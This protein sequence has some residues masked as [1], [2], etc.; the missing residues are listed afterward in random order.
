MEK[1]ATRNPCSRIF[2]SVIS[3][4]GGEIRNHGATRQA[5]RVQPR[6][7]VP[8]ARRPSPERRR[9]L[10]LGACPPPPGSPARL[11]QTETAL[12]EEWRSLWFLAPLLWQ[13]CSGV[14]LILSTEGCCIICS[15]RQQMSGLTLA[16]W[17]PTPRR[18]VDNHAHVPK[19]FPPLLRFA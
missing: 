6:S 10:Y 8:G 11:S 17:S 13:T 16:A 3:K 1:I 18:Q 15:R 4:L 19:R 14:K 7:G 9:A 2:E 12:H 5:G